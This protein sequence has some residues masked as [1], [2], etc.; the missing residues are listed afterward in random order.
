MGFGEGHLP[1]VWFH[2]YDTIYF[3]IMDQNCALHP[4]PI[5]RPTQ[6]TKLLPTK[7]STVLKT[8]YAFPPAF[9]IMFPMCYLDIVMLMWRRLLEEPP[10]S[11]NT[12]LRVQE[13]VL[14]HTH[15]CTGVKA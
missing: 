5:P 13:Y 1:P 15:T 11:E 4:N 3:F 10:V 2:H 7:C 9:F 14:L 6:Q 12:L 8:I